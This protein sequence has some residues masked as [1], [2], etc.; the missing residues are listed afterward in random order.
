MNK[1]TVVPID[2]AVYV[3]GVSLIGLDLSTAQIPDEVHA[4]Q[5]IGNIDP[6]RGWIEF[7]QELG[8]P[9][10]AIEELPQWAL[11]AQALWQTRMD[12]INDPPVVPLTQQ[13]FANAIKKQLNDVAIARNYENEYSIASYVSST[14]PQWQQEAQAF[15]AWR[16]A[17]WLYAYSELALVQAGDKPVPTIEQFLEGL[18]DLIW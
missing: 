3:D 1:L 6:P 2:G 16:D 12:E 13:D 7:K 18:P 14:N 5:W 15:V 9:N 17:V 11:T 4:L 10:E 8:L